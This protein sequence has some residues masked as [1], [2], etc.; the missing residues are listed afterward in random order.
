MGAMTTYKADLKRF[1]EDALGRG[2]T[3]IVVTSMNR[4]TFDPDGQSRT[5]WAITRRPCA[6]FPPKSTSRWWI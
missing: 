5:A 3:P 2:A 6:R 1:V 4:L